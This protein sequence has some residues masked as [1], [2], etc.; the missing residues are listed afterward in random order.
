M[1]EKPAAGILYIV[2]TPIGNPADITRRAV[3]IL[4]FVDA[5]ICEERKNGARLLKELGLSKTLIELNE[6]NE[7]SLIQEILVLLMQG[8]SLA[9]ISDCGT[10]VFS[11]PGRQL[12]VLLEE[13]N[14]QVVPVPGASSLMAAVS[15]CPFNLE[16]FQFVGFLPPKTEQ[17]QAAL[18]R[19]SRA[20]LPLILMDT[21]YRLA[22]LLGEVQQAFGKKQRVFL[23]CDL[24]LPSEKLYHGTIEDVIR[25]TNNRKAEFILILDKPQRKQFGGP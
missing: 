16:Q 5:V 11:D 8:Q 7:S 24:T 13:M 19:L 2:A 10:P 20:D 9:L 3:D 22:K 17:R 21:P 15:V 18:A 6:H 12:L 25:Q 4:N 1:A 14:I 23:A